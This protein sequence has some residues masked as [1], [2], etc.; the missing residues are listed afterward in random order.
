[1]DLEGRNFIRPSSYPWGAA[2]VFM[3]KP[4]GLL[5]ICIDYHKLHVTTIKNKHHLSRIDDLFDN[6]SEVTVFSLLDLAMWFHKLRVVEDS[7]PLTAFWTRYGLYECLAMSFGLTNAPTF[8]MDLMNQVFQEY[9]DGFM[10]VF[11]DDFL[12]Y[13]KDERAWTSS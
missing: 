12:V 7:I 10:L 13:S 2:V 4:N 3:K 5:R 11:K 9:L 8:F 6:L 1:M